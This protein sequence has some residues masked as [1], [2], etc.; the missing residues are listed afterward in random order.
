[1]F[2]ESEAEMNSSAPWERDVR[3]ENAFRGHIPPL[4]GWKSI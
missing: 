1:M 3:D 2:I 4:A